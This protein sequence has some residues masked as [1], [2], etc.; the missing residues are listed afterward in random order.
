M[1]N[2]SKRRH[3][4]IPAPPLPERY[5]AQ[6]ERLGLNREQLGR[7]ARL[8]PRAVEAYE[9]QRRNPP[10]AAVTKIANALARRQRELA[11]RKKAG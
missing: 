11:S 1:K 8:N 3:G 7:M 10:P 2:T 6:R 4:P 5:Q 9:Q